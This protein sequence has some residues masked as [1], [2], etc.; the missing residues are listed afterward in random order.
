MLTKCQRK[1]FRFS[2]ELVEKLIS[3][4]HKEQIEIQ[5]TLF[6]TWVNLFYRYTGMEHITVGI[7]MQGS[8]EKV[9]PLSIDFS[10]TNSFT[11]QVKENNKLLQKQLDGSISLRSS[12]SSMIKP[13]VI[14]T[15]F[16]VRDE[17]ASSFAGSTPSSLNDL[18]Q[19]KIITLEI[20]RNGTEWTGA[21]LY[22]E[23]HFEETAMTRMLGHLQ[24]LSVGYLDQPEVQIDQIPMLTEQEYTQMLNEWNSASTKPAESPCI[25]Y[26]FE[27]QVRRTPDAVA[28]VYGKERLTY[29]ELD[30]RANQLANYLLQKEIGFEAL[31][32]VHMKRSI[33]MVVAILGILKAGGAYVP[34]DPAYATERLSYILEDTK[35]Q[36]LLTQD[37]LAESFVEHEIEVVYLDRDR[38]AIMEAGSH[39][40]LNSASIKGDQ[41]AYVVY[42]SGSTG[43]SK[44][45]AVE[46]SSV[47]AIIQ[48]AQEVYTAEEIAGVLGSTSINFDLSVFEMFVTWSMGGKLILAENALQLP[49]LPAAS[50]VTLINTVPSAIRELV[51]IKGIPA[52]V[53]TV[54]LCGEPLKRALVEQIYE[55]ETVEKIFNLYGPSEDTTYSTYS[56]VDRGSELPVFIGRPIHNTQAYVLDKHL[57][58]VP[59]GVSGELYLSGAGLARGYLNRVELTREKFI[60]NVFSNQPNERMYRTGDLVR[61]VEDGNLEYL[62]RMD[63]QVKIRG[64]RIELG[65]IESTLMNHPDVHETVVVA[66]EFNSADLRLV[67]YFTTKIDI[68]QGKVEQK[69][70]GYSQLI[71]DLRN[72][73]QQK[74]PEYMIPSIF[75]PLEQI[76]LTA[77]GKIDRQSLPQP[78]IIQRH[79]A[80]P[81]NEIEERLVSIWSDVLQLE[82][83]G[84]EDP[85]LD[86]GGQSILATQILVR[87]RSE[88]EI[89]LTQRKVFEA[90]TIAKQAQ[91][92]AEVQKRGKIKPTSNVIVPR[93]RVARKLQG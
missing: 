68:K 89:D 93:K 11:D 69:K 43:K 14:H 19:E 10:K 78:K 31:I 52:T 82:S 88:F 28:I 81:R 22:H 55:V 6:T 13:N 25:P 85:F 49:H 38:D 41:L 48:W 72:Y 33:D 80:A 30:Q 87:I 50:E 18:R 45:V 21:L 23:E 76:P 62:G 4:S 63:H 90:T 51:R 66:K 24:Q 35:A 47:I 67:A 71:R 60:P 73:L 77:N 84:V 8:H 36:V 46:H 65:E 37:S 15:G 58:P 5:V 26:W 2:G 20:V 44:G 57:N 42:T 54:N 1:S 3:F 61:Y 16:F 32:G 29:V 70:S 53:R 83:V 12:E 34:L 56:I 74:L 27:A 7:E 9:I 39:T 59:I 92:I 40:P 17:T 79:H 64:F 75:M 91:V 86:V